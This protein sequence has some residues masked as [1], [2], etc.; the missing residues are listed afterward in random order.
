MGIAN[1]TDF[2]LK[3]HQ[4]HARED[5]LYFDQES[6]EK[7][8]PYVIE[9]SLGV[10]RLTLGLLCDAY[11]EEAVAENDTRIVLKLHHAIA[12]IKAAVLPL[13]KKLAEPAT[14]IYQELCRHFVADYDDSGSIGKRYRR[15][16]EVGTPFCI[17]Y[18]F[19]SQ[20]DNAVTVRFRDSM[21]QERVKIAELV[22]FLQEKLAY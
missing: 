3:A 15:Y 7:Y 9:P 12:P 20:E 6:G 13:S 22:A 14:E 16:D 1:R 21:E 5:M 2:D 8:V 17:T 11:H 18:D 10:D 19:D 4:E